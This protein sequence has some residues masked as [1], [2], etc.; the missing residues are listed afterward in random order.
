MT[1][2]ELKTLLE[3]LSLDE[4]IQMIHG[5]EFFKNSGVAQKDI[6]AFSF[7]DGPMGPRLEYEPANWL[8]IGGNDDYTS[9]LPCNSALAATFN[10]ERAYET[11]LLL[12]QE[13]RAREKDMILAPGINIHR[14]PLGGR[15]FEYMSED[16]YLTGEIAVPYVKGVQETDVSA[17]VKH[18]A[19]NNQETYRNGTDV[20][21]S[22]R[23]LWEIYLPAY[24]AT[25]LEGKAL[26][27]MGAYN[28]YN[29]E[30]LC[31]NQQLVNEILRGEWGFD[32]IFVSDW[33]A[34]HDTIKA[35]L[36]EIDVDMRVTTDFDE[37]PMANPLK[38]AILNGEIE[39]SHLDK[40]V[41]HLLSV[42]NRLHMLDG[43]RKRGSF[44]T[45]EHHAA[46]L[47]TAEE[48]IVLLKN[49][50]NLLP[51]DENRIKN[52]LLIGDNADRIHAL[53]GGSAEIKALY[54][55]SPLMGFKMISGGSFH[56][57]YE[58]GY[59]NYVIGNAW[60]KENAQVAAKELFDDDSAINPDLLTEKDIQRLAGVFAPN[61][62]RQSRKILSSQL[63][64]KNKEY[65]DRALEK[66]KNADV[67]IYIGGLNH[68][69]DVEGADRKDYL[70]PNNQDEIILKLL[71]IRPDAIITLIGGSPVS[72]QAWADK[73]KAIVY[74]YYAGMESGLALAKT[75][76]GMV[77]PSGKLPT[78]FPANI[79]DSPAHKL[80]TFPGGMSASY[81]EGIFVGYRYFETENIKPAFCFGHGLSYASFQYKNLAVKDLAPALTEDIYSIRNLP[82][83]YEVRFDVCN[84]SD[85]DALETGMLF[86]SAP[87]SFTTVTGK[88]EKRP[89][90]ELRSFDKKLIAAGKKETYCFNLTPMD[91]AYYD[92]ELHM[93][94]VK[95]GD[96]TIMAGRNVADLPLTATIHIDKDLKISRS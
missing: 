5:A 45:P 89:A 28:K 66:A 3:S 2:Q 75:L 92:E 18:Y 59:Y 33:G 64:A 78:T 51:I 54:E 81:D 7:S 10:R 1:D 19:L 8:P 53:G 29:G 48:S 86:V 85:R 43:N 27:F 87:T 32:G 93:Y 11:G 47:K 91:F 30:Y 13:T 65:L 69:H 83:L 31:E 88:D 68:D 44:N 37:Y 61:A 4:K 50:D 71:E 79:E 95:S 12:G 73:A 20:T 55:I 16:P 63:E 57:D 74:S 80:S 76:M 60:G 22:E 14:S 42:M 9:Y 34:T 40:K 23:A 39:E 35:G 52:I 26:G 21:V 41:W 49:E 70:L 77:C 56:V 72:T 96:Y 38:Q 82:N 84:T 15:N 36:C 67:V 25:V 46:L 24:R 62:P 58:P 17:C 6:P 90:K 94:A